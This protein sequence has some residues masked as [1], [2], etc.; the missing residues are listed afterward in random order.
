MS[1]SSSSSANASAPNLPP[2]AAIPIPIP[3]LPFTIFFYSIV[4]R[5][6]SI[7]YLLVIFIFY[8]TIVLVTIL[9]GSNVNPNALIGVHRLGNMSMWPESPLNPTLGQR[10]QH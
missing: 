10:P 1:S 6:A 4:F 7:L 5:P 3:T 2:S 8:L 9:R